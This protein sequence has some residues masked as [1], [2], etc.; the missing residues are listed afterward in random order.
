MWRSA[1]RGRALVFRRGE[2]VNLNRAVVGENSAY[3][4]TPSHR[5]DDTTKGADV[6]V[7]TALQF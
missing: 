2:L 5:L 6:H 4:Q 1:N 7:G 3:F